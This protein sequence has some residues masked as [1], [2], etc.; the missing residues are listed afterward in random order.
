MPEYFMPVGNTDFKEIRETG[1]YYI[2]KTMLIDQLVGR[3]RAKVT[4]FTR[5]RRFGKSLNMSMLQHF[6]D[7]REKSESLFEGLQISENKKLCDSWMNK[8]PTILVSFKD[9]GG[10]GFKES[11]TR[12]KSIISKLYEAHLYLIKECDN[13]EPFNVRKFQAFLEVCTNTTTSMLSC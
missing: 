5:P 7:I 12:L 4:L 13:I 10:V 8:Y 9:A 1:L 11:L 6:F 2:D 3:S